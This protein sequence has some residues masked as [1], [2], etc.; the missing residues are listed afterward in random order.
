MSSRIS[1]IVV[2]LAM[3]APAAGC[4]RVMVATPVIV[5]QSETN[6][7]ADVPAPYR[8]PEAE[9]IYVTDRAPEPTKKHPVWYG[10]HRSPQLCYGV[11]KVN[12][13]RDLSWEEIA[14]ETWR[15]RK[16]AIPIS[17]GEVTEMGR[18][19][20]TIP[21]V[22]MVNGQPVE[23]PAV[24]EE[25][26]RLRDQFHEFLARRLAVTARKDVYVFVHGFNNTFE[27]PMYVMAQMW[28]FAGRQGVPIVYTWPAGG[29]GLLR[30][31]TYDRESGE[32]TVLHL[33][34]FLMALGEAPGVENVHLIA[35]SRGTDVALTALRE[36]HI[37]FT[38]AGRHTHEELRLKTATLC[39]PD[40]DA[41]VVTQ[42]FGPER[43]DQAPERFTVYVSKHDEAI[44]I[45]NWLFKSTTRIG[46]LRYDDLLP[47]QKHSLALLGK[48][49]IIDVRVKTSGL[50]HSYFYEHP[51]VSSDLLLM[52]KD[53]KAPGAE[54]G[55]PLH[56]KAEGWWELLPEYLQ[57]AK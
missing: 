33:K 50:G 45:A 27:H 56:K 29:G 53:G 51:Q 8:T 57:E 34:R 21:K 23:D 48:M 31:Y 38:A 10:A 52:L 20:S 36:L 30:G 4:G 54:N 55:R 9:V 18:M 28:H 25:R 46:R 11:C 44:G 17:I 37:H 16:R 26:E 35:H 47:V 43:L 2:A 6:P 39:A 24:V 42:R 13:G 3:L 14:R 5:A 41:Q 22:V 7:Y 49:S 32:Y 19:P 12:L 40:L 1:R 15:D